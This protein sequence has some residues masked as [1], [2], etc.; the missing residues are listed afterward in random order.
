MTAPDSLKRFTT[1]AS[2]GGI[3]L[4]SI[5]DPQEVKIPLV[6]NKSLCAIGNP[7]SNL[8]LPLAIN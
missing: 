1:V 2:Y 3:K 8:C 6:Q 5:L 7:V 4:F